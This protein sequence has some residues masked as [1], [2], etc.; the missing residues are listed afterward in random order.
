VQRALLE[1]DT[2]AVVVSSATA[3]EIATKFRLGR[4]PDANVLTPDYLGSLRKLQAQELAVSSRHV[5]RA[6]LF[7]V[8]HRDPVDRMLA[9]QALIEALPLIS[10]DPVFRD[11]EV[12]VIW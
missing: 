10:K 6:G 7:D 5:L 3:W 2:T 11:F 8:P 9:A 4:F 12:S 1:D